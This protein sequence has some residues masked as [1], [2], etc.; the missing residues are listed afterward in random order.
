MKI[1]ITIDDELLSRAD[2]FAKK[3]YLSRSGLISYALN[4][5][6]TQKELFSAIASMGISMQK[7]ADK[8]E[9][10]DDFKAEL[11]NFY[12]LAAIFTQK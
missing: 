7:L 11:E 8:K 12:K 5:Y 9:I 1:N 3:N 2:D 10:D 4:D 6:L